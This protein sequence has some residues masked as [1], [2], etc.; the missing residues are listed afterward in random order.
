M[1]R[2]WGKKTGRVGRRKLQGTANDV[3]DAV[4]SGNGAEDADVIDGERGVTASFK[5]DRNVGQRVDQLRIGHVFRKN[6]ATREV[7]ADSC[8]QG[9]INGRVR[10]ASVGGTRGA[11]CIPKTDHSHASITRDEERVRDRAHE[12]AVGAGRSQGHHERRCGLHAL[13]NFPEAHGEGVGGINRWNVVRVVGVAAGSEGERDER[14]A[15]DM[16]KG[17]GHSFRTVLMAYV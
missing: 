1:L 7:K 16:Q 11:R 13:R 12:C 2:V 6:T 8:F 14:K 5:G 4:L 9:P 3:D 15:S 17:A 10:V